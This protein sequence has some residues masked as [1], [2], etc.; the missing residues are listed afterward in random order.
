MAHSDA[1]ENTS[2]VRR[3]VA[4]VN[5]GDLDTID[6]LFAPEYVNHVPQGAETGPTA[7]LDSSSPGSGE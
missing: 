6:E 2:L 7:I 1:E 5:S 3:Y 4:A